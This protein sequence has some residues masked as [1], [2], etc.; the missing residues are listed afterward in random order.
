MNQLRRVGKRWW[1]PGVLVIVLAVG[2]TLAWPSLQRYA[3]ALGP[4][5][6]YRQSD[7]ALVP[8]DPAI[9]AVAHNAGNNPDTTSV[10]LEYRADVIEADVITARGELVAGRNQPWRW[11][12]ELVFQGPALAEV[13]DDVPADVAMLL[14]LKRDSPGFVNQLTHFLRERAGTRQVWLS[15]PDLSLLRELQRRVPGVSVLLTLAFPDDVA[16]LRAHPGWRQVIDGVSVF[17]GLVDRDLLGWLHQRQVL[18]FAWTV[19]SARQA[20]TLVQ[21]GV[22]GI[23]TDNLAILRATGR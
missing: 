10:A 1:I 7:L 20:R 11:L 18:V 13:W 5:Q 8:H 14:D 22:D 16:S 6:F 3:G 19:N 17:H 15:S 2:L 4:P 9:I 12:A 23:T 21:D